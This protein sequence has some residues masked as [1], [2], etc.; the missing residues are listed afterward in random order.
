MYLSLSVLRK[1][2]LLDFQ[3]VSLFEV[4]NG[5]AR[6]C[7]QCEVGS[8]ASLEYLRHRAHLGK[9]HPSSLAFSLILASDLA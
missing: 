2:H 9:P 7:L 5:G 8:V 4:I 3:G 1:S 6:A